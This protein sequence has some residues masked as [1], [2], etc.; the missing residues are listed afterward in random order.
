MRTRNT[1]EMSEIGGTPVTLVRI[2]EGDSYVWLY[3]PAFIKS[4]SVMVDEP[5]GGRFR[6]KSC[7]HAHYSADSSVQDDW[8]RTDTSQLPAPNAYV[9]SYCPWGWNEGPF[10]IPSS[11]FDAGGVN[12]YIPVSEVTSNDED[13]CVL[14]AYNSFVTGLR[15][16][17]AS[18]SIAESGETP[19]L[20]DIWQRRKAAPSNIV[21]GF[22]NYSFG[23][24][25]LISDLRA[26]AR[27]MR[28][29]PKTVR[30]RLKQ[31]GNKQVRRSYKFDLSATV[32]DLTGTLGT[33]M[34]YSESWRNYD[35]AYYT[36]NK[37]R[38]F[39]VTIRANVKPKLGPAGQ[40]I[41]N[42]LATLGLIPSLA[43][44]WQ[45]TRLSFAIDWF[46]NIGG[47]IENL[48]GSL[49]HDIS[50]IDVCVTEIRER[51]VKF[52]GP[53]KGSTNGHELAVV[54]QRV[55]I[56]KKV[57]VPLLPVFKLPR[58]PMQYVL[59]ALIGLTT[60]KKGK[61]ILSWLDKMSRMGN[62]Q[63]SAINKSLTN[64]SPF[65]KE[66]YRLATKSPFKGFKNS[67]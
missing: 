23:W 40:D 44:V 11:I 18:Q 61:L 25:P 39:V 13:D 60:T 53:D 1:T 33:N 2:T 27:E 45:L 22:L 62:K 42:K 63:L 43:T 30:K 24:R 65:Y 9:T 48:Q 55:F 10:I 6:T 4:R 31:I 64:K 15:A 52:T 28:S 3:N 20:F 49:T 16:L 38:K 5:S 21:N 41:V 12:T 46:Y 14:K 32:N 7:I 8:S 56:R 57:D 58:R 17:D 59:L 35:Y 19:R 26:I 34:S 36:V 37:S 66:M 29:F 54:K 47:A 51:Y 67:K 50:N